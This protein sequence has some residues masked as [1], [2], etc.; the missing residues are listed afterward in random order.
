MK[1]MTRHCNDATTLPT[2]ENMVSHLEACIKE[3]GG[4][5]TFIVRALGVNERAQGMKQVARLSDLSPMRASTKH[6]ME[7]APRAMTPS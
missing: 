3:A 6:C 2:P 1:S 5:A 4:D 7:N